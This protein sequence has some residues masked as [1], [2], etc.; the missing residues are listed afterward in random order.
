MIFDSLER[1][2]H[3]STHVSSACSHPL[4]P[5]AL[6]IATDY[7]HIIAK[8]YEVTLIRR[9]NSRDQNVY[10]LMNIVIPPRNRKIT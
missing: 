4:F 2:N 1:S 9:F 5:L 3:E 8:F 10:T 7:L 6:S